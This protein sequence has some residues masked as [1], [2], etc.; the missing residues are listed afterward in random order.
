MNVNTFLGSYTCTSGLLYCSNIMQTCPTLHCLN[1]I[2]IYIYTTLLKEDYWH[3][4][5]A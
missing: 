4:V 2:H 5:V 1:L 3:D